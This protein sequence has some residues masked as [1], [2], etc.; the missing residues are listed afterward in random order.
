MRHIKARVR[1]SATRVDDRVEDGR[2]TRDWGFSD[3]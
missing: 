2:E 1:E 3:E